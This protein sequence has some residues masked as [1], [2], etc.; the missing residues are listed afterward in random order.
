MGE[1]QGVAV[2]GRRTLMRLRMRRV[3]AVM[4]QPVTGF[5]RMGECRRGQEVAVVVRRTLVRRKAWRATAAMRRQA[6]FPRPRKGGKGPGAAVVAVR[7]RV[8]LRTV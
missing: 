8:M 2:V 4:R 5:L 6:G 3:L 1:R 7:R